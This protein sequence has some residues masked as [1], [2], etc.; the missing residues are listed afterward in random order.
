MALHINIEELLSAS[1][2]ENE[3]IEFKEGWNP[4]S[5]Y[6]T[7]CAFAN[8]FD[9]IGGGY[10]VIGVKENEITKT[11]ERPVL[12]VS[13]SDLADIQLKMIGFNNLIKPEYSP[14]FFI[15]DLDG[16]QIIILWVPGGSNRPYQVPDLITSKTKNYFYYIRKY[17]ST[18]KANIDEQQELISLANQ[19]PFD[20]RSNTQAHVEN[21]SMLLIKDFLQKTKSKLVTEIGRV[22]DLSI[23]RQMEL[24]SGPSELLFP[25]N[26]A[27]M[28]FYN[29]PHKFFP[30]SQVDIVEFPN[31]E[32]NPYIENEPI[33]G[34][35][36]SQIE[37]TLNILRDKIIKEKVIKSAN[38][39]ESLRISS[40]P[41]QAI[42]EILVNAFYHRDYQQREP[43]EIRIYSNSVVFINQGG[44]DRSIQ[45]QSFTEGS[46]RSRR[47]RNRRLGEF[48]KEL[49]LTEGRATGIPTVLKSLAQNG[50]PEPEFRTDAERTFFEVELHIHP[51]FY[52]QAILTGKPSNKLDELLSNLINSNGDIVRDVV[53]DIAGDIAR[54]VV[55]DIVRDNVDYIAIKEEGDFAGVLIADIATEIVS[56]A[57]QQTKDE[58]SQAAQEI[59]N[60]HLLKI[61]ELC[62]VPRQRKSV[63]EG[64]GLSANVK[65]FNTYMAPLVHKGLLQM[66]IPDKPTN[67]NQKYVTTLKGY[68]IAGLLKAKGLR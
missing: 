42:E 11:A 33:K 67:P 29:E 61:L 58:I 62:E 14:K 28:L 50:S 38:K 39:A 59:F 18:V 40:Y 21:I 37:R 13:T 10:I 23:F 60:K 31:G 66:T 20:D 57:N 8:D 22:D 4:D 35:I 41:L 56:A 24:I 12:G 48:L 5:I 17:A 34:P 65:N 63:F 30:C 16:K 2:V 1:K 55:G 51:A 68:I 7:I 54:D 49:D 19:V 53:G 44:P 32:A 45:L 9:N 25:R 47:Y 43:I 15:E 26:I 6:R 3:R 64:I 36:P 27:L 46:I 52:E